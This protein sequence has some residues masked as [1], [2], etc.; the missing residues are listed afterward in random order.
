[1]NRSVCNKATGW[2]LNKVGR[3]VDDFYEE[4][5]RRYEGFHA[6]LREELDFEQY[7]EEYDRCE[8][9]EEV[10]PLYENAD[11]TETYLDNLK[12]YSDENMDLT[13]RYVAAAEE[14]A[15]SLTGRLEKVRL[16]VRHKSLKSEAMIELL[17]KI[18]VTHPDVVDEVFHDKLVRWDTQV[19]NRQALDKLEMA[20][21]IT[22]DA[23]DAKESIDEARIFCSTL[24]DDR[25]RLA[26]S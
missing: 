10:Q 26:T 19:Q 17:K 6:K 5:Q 3:R 22:N 18:S 25:R 12:N 16:E 4:M 24:R 11:E 20:K 1:M 2:V 13:T 14:T 21:D 7:K 23:N 9:A 8:D 15:N